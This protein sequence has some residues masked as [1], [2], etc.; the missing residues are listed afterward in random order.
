MNIQITRDSIIKLEVDAIVNPANS[1]G[2]MGGGVA[3]VIKKAAGKKIEMAAMEQ[4]PI[5]IGKA[6]LTHAGKLNC[7][8][9]I[10]APTMKMP[11]QKTSTENVAKAVV[12]VL[13]LAYEYDLKK[14]AM[15]GMGTGTGRVPFDEAAAAMIDAIKKEE[16]LK[17]PDI[18]IILVDKDAKMIQAW[19]DYLAMPDNDEEE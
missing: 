11:A 3:A 12:A 4:A 2:E 7:E 13:R 15:P 14:I 8:F 6:I 10:H 1:E 18:E 17:N 16:F 19:E 9:I 5:P